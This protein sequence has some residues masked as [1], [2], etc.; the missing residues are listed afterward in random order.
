V[1]P[2][3]YAIPV[4]LL[5]ILIEAWIA[6]R[7]GAAVYHVGDAV[8]SL[9]LGVL[10]Q[11]TNSFAKLATLGIYAAVYENF[12]AATW[13]TDRVVAWVVA[14]LVYDFFYYW[15]HRLSH[16]VAVLWA[17][18]VVHHSSEYFNLSTA[19]RQTSTGTALG[20]LFYLPM[21]VAG[22]PPAMFVAVALINL[23]YQ[24]WPHTQLIGKLGWVDRVF[25][26]PSNHRVHHGQNDYCMDRN[27]GGILIV[28][29]RLFG[30]F[31]EE[32]EDEKVC[33]GVRKPLA[34]FNPLWGNAHYYVDLWHA[35]RRARGWRDK[36]HVWLSPPG[37]WPMGPMQHFEPREFR[38]FEPGTPLPLI[39]YAVVHYTL[40]TALLTHFLLVFARLDSIQ[41]W[42]YALAIAVSVLSIGGLLERVGWARRLEQLRLFVLGA[43]IVALPLWFG[44]TMPAALRAAL[45]LVAAASLVWISRQTMRR[46]AGGAGAAA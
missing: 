13:P 42:T 28:W 43:A 46:E 32:R 17:A 16:E 19:L 20:W 26:T 44:S 8:T 18:H 22:V 37:G 38:K 9:H 34:S 36:L 11:V 7:R 4:F 15:F 39:S 35:S 40:S 24:Y 2:I 21:A 41:A 31:A 3:V 23:L 25:V 27:Y 6:H 14:L 33:F 5:T 45:G 30:S 29:D 12:R 1:N 10:S